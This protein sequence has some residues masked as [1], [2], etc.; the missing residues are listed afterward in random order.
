MRM[1]LDGRNHSRFVFRSYVTNIVFFAINEL[2]T[3][4]LIYDFVSAFLRHNLCISASAGADE[5]MC[6]WH[7]FPEKKHGVSQAGLVSPLTL[8]KWI[9]WDEV[10]G[11]FWSTFWGNICTEPD[12]FSGGLTFAYVYAAQ[13]R[14]WHHAN[15]RLPAY[16]SAKALAEK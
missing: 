9:R 12:P 8:D 3:L 6:L 11:R 4:F 2:V 14:H 1:T 16:D 5:A 7:C 13:Q 15:A 10:E